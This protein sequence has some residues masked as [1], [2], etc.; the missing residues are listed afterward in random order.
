MDTLLPKSTV[1]HSEGSWLCFHARHKVVRLPS[2]ALSP[3]VD[4]LLLDETVAGLNNARLVPPL[5]VLVAVGPMGVFVRVGVLVGG[6]EVFVG[7]FVGPPGVLV[8]VG[9]GVFVRVGVEVG[10]FV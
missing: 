7:V 1:I 4:V 8:A 10:V 5:A 3:I 6:T 2:T 9:M